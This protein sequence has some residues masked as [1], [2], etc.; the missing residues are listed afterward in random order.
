MW[1][2]FF[3]HEYWGLYVLMEPVDSKQLDRAK[4]KREPAEEYSYK[5][6]TRRPCLRRSF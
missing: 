4:L 5:S 3:N 6:V 2:S 1:R